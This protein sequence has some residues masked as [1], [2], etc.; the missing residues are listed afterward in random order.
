[1]QKISPSYRARE[2]LPDGRILHVRPIRPDDRDKLREEFLK[3]SPASVRDRF[4]NVKLDLTPGELTYF[5]E[6]DFST[7]V[8][9][10]AE[11]ET[12]IGLQ[13][14]GVG[15]FVRKQ[16]RSDHCETAIT[17]ADALQG[18]GIG[19][20]LL[21]QLINCARELGISRFDA[22]V[23]PQNKKMARLLYRTGLPIESS[24]EDGVLTYSLL[25]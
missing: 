10:V 19:R 8:A 22:S 2:R 1:M 17:V 9:L 23:L 20:I 25:L 7:H 18:L 21:R 4:F 14:A 5:T 11:L 12:D 13:P 16:D 6:V 15:R 3:L 24:I